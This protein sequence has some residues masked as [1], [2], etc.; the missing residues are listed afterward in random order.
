M[1]IEAQV[2]ELANEKG[3]FGVS[4]IAEGVLCVRGDGK[5]RSGLGWRRSRKPSPRRGRSSGPSCGTEEREVCSVGKPELA[6]GAP[7][8][9]L[10]K[11]GTPK[12]SGSLERY[13]PPAKRGA[14]ISEG[15]SVGAALEGP[16]R[17][18]MEAKPEA[19]SAERP[20]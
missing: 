18:G 4:R 15:W 5:A 8:N 17:S 13:R 11:I 3:R 10:R 16:E 2:S 6:K 1:V 7:P 14:G 20:I 9:T 19:L 12:R